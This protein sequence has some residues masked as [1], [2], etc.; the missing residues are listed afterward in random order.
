MILS[1]VRLCIISLCFLSVFILRT[2]IA[3]RVCLR[4]CPLYFLFF[5]ILNIDFKVCGRVIISKSCLKLIYLTVN[6]HILQEK[7]NPLMQHI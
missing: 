7:W 6:E 4:I 1:L 3:K 5:S 2:K